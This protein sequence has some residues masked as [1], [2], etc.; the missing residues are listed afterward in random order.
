MFEHLVNQRAKARGDTPLKVLEDKAAVT[1]LARQAD[2]LMINYD[3]MGRA[4][5]AIAKNHPVDPFHNWWAAST[6]NLIRKTFE[7]PLA[8]KMA[9]Q[10]EKQFRATLSAERQR[11]RDN[12][13]IRM[14][15]MVMELD[16]PEQ[17]QLFLNLAY[18]SLNEPSQIDPMKLLTLGIILEPKTNRDMVERKMAA[19]EGLLSEV[20]TA[21]W[22]TLAM[23]DMGLAKIWNGMAGRSDFWSLDRN[24]TQSV[25][26]KVLY[27]LM[28]AGMP[29]IWNF[30]FLK[31][32]TSLFDKKRQ[33]DNIRIYGHPRS[34]MLDLG[35]A[36]LVLRSLGVP[37]NRINRAEMTNRWGRT[38]ESKI[39]DINKKYGDRIKDAK[40]RKDYGEV[41]IANDLR[42]D[43]IQLIQAIAKDQ[44]A[45]GFYE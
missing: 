34:G 13:P 37:L 42:R 45:E 5:V 27:S 40:L 11:A 26:E 24:P 44:S 30:Y 14:R 19:A 39:Q 36:E 41:R 16:S 7:N 9:M 23:T 21:A 33:K 15:G 32:M 38:F 18:A 31:E 6:S 20:G 29:N 35:P 1:E 4:N 17:E 2:D 22:N 10:S 12:L 43:V 8:N 3:G 28:D 25:P